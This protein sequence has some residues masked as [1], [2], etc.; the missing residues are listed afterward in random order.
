[1]EEIASPPKEVRISRS[2]MRVW[3]PRVRI[4][5]L[6]LIADR[7]KPIVF[8]FSAERGRVK[9]LRRGIEH[10]AMRFSNYI[11]ATIERHCEE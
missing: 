9:R 5:L 3:G 10:E 7:F 4:T 8:L 1:M 11:G 6:L 2:E